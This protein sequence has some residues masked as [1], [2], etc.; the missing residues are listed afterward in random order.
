[1][2]KNVC[3]AG[4]FFISDDAQRVW[5]GIIYPGG[6]VRRNMAFDFCILLSGFDSDRSV[7]ELEQRSE[8]ELYHYG[9]LRCLW[10]S[11]KALCPDWY[12]PVVGSFAGDMRSEKGRARRYGEAPFSCY[13][14][15]GSYCSSGNDP[16]CSFFFFHNPL[17]CR[18][19][20]A[21]RDMEPALCIGEWT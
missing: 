20:T 11:G 15:N 4:S 14:S 16:E 9:K 2:Q 5:R 8:E 21:G 19:K 1:M 17:N 18:A 12:V 10:I 6:P 3:F 13:T 7:P